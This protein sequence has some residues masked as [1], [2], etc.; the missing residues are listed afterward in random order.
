MDWATFFKDNSTSIFTLAGV[1]LGSVITFFISYLNNR[2]EATERSKDREE[3]R[4]EAK[5]QLTLE[6]KRKD[7]EIIQNTIDNALKSMEIVLET[8][9]K[10][11]WGR[12]SDEEVWE[13]LKSAILDEKSRMHQQGESDMIA[14]KLAF[15]LGDEFHSD[16][17]KFCDLCAEYWS[18]MLNSSYYSKEDQ[19]IAFFNAAGSAAKLHNLMNEKLISLRD[20]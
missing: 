15:T 13:E 14:E 12:I 20:T 6:L 3:Q 2:F 17:R 8:R 1:F 16:Y 9:T 5:T 7:I 4:R 19:D 10:E 11:S 18:R